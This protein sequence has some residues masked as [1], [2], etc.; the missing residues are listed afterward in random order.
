MADN[1]VEH[2][3]YDYYG[4]GDPEAWGVHYAPTFASPRT[5]TPLEGWVAVHIGLKQ[6][7]AEKYFW[8]EGREPDVK[9]GN[10][11]WLYH[12]TAQ[13]RIDATF[14]LAREPLPGGPAP[15]QEAPR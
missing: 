4:E 8:L 9:L 10:T 12:L 6:R 11:I 14:K 3:S 7:M 15:P 1:Q 2:I 13:D 5:F